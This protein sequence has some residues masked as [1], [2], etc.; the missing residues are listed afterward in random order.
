[1]LCCLVGVSAMLPIWLFAL[2]LAVRGYE[3]V[4]GFL[5][6]IRVA[7]SLSILLGASIVGLSACRRLRDLGW[8]PF[9][10]GLLAIPGVNAATLLV[11]MLKKGA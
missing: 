7:G 2:I 5:P 1:M 9:C 4:E 11:L 6:F 3:S 8:S 10:A